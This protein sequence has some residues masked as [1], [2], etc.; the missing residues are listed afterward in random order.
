MSTVNKIFGRKVCLQRP[1]MFCLT[2]KNK[3]K[4]L[5]AHDS[6]KVMRSNPGYLLK[7]SLLYHMLYHFL[8]Q[9]SFTTYTS[10]NLHS[11]K[12]N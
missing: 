2:K 9:I 1:A 6:L 7:S 8:G 10:D 4:I 12:E 5:N 3:N 11:E